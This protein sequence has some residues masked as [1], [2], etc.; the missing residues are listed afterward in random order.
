MFCAC[1][2]LK[3][4]KPHVSC[5]VSDYYWKKKNNFALIDQFLTIKQRLGKWV[6]TG[7]L[8]PI[9]FLIGVVKSGLKIR[10]LS[11]EWKDF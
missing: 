8:A 6:K 1:C 9:F 11:H 2:A 4:L 3:R 10:Y 5:T 7:L